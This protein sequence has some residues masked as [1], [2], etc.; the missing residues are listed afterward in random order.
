MEIMVV[1]L[2]WFWIMVKFDWDK[3]VKFWQYLMVS[4]ELV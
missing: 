1:K 4:I 2:G 3:N